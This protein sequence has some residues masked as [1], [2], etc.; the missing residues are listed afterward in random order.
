MK[1]DE[2]KEFGLVIIESLREN[3]LKTGTLLH[4][5]LMKNKKFQEPTLSSFLYTVKTKEE[6]FQK[7][8]EIIVRI[9][10]DK[11]FPILHFEMHGFEDG[12][13]LS[14]NE[15]VGWNEL[16]PI[17]REINILLSNKLTIMMG[18]CRGIT[19]AFEIDT[20]K[21][22]P[23]NLIIGTIRDI[24]GIELLNG[25]DAFYDNYF[26]TFDSVKSTQLMN[27]EIDAIQSTFT[28]LKAEYFFDILVEHDRTAKH[29]IIERERKNELKDKS[30]EEIRLFTENE[31]K[32]I[33][34]NYDDKDYF[35]MTDLKE[36]DK[37]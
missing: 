3:D 37:P 11:L 8:T 6:L 14:S 15:I 36:K 18:M 2:V 22:A 9:K 28:Y 12:I 34:G 29:S 1:Y 21:R 17:F 25:Y 5:G 13:Q 24:N 4:N 19:I 30:T 26:F 10:I 33:F 23:F 32:N 16:L 35:L 7:L 31:I 20:S 27:N